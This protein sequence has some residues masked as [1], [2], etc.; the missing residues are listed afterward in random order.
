[1]Q[2]CTLHSQ[3]L[4]PV[5]PVIRTSWRCL[6]RS[7]SHRSAPRRTACSHV[8]EADTPAEPRASP[9]LSKRAAL[10][11]L[12]ATALLVSRP[13][14]AVAAVY[15][16]EVTQKVYFDVKVGDQAPERIIMGLYGNEVPKT[17]ANFAALATGE[18]GYGYKGTI[19]H[20]VI[21]NFML[22]GG[23]FERFNGTGG[24]SIYGSKFKDENFDIPHSVGSLSMAN[25][26]PNTNGSQFFITVAETPWLDG[27]HVVFGK[28]LEGQALV[29][30]IENLPVDRS[31]KPSQRVEIVASG[32]L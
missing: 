2:S 18:K 17:A 14:V 1:M 22:Q 13:A 28:L 16:P 24:K 30:R 10:L 6:Q 32:L 4:H 21:K 3:T 11:S 7:S 20:R 15:A 9:V 23:D 26:G 27:K 31:S 5:R 29:K 8:R 12:S 19:F 25:A